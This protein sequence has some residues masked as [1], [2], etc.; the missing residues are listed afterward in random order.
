MRRRAVAL[1][2]ALLGAWLASGVVLAGPASAHAELESSNPEDGA[3]LSSA[4]GQVTLHFSE[5]VS[6]GAGYARVLDARQQRVDTGAPTVAGDVLT[7]PLRDN[8]PEGG[9]LV[10][11]RVISADSHPVAGAFSFAVGNGPLITAGAGDVSETTAPG[12]AVAL[13][14]TRWLGYAGLA[15]AVGIPVLLMVCWPVGW[16]SVR[17]R[18]L[19]EGGAIAA[20]LGAL[21]AFAVQGPYAAGAG[22]GSVFD[23]A[24]LDTTAS[25]SYGVVLMIRTLLALYLVAALAPAWRRGRPPTSWMLPASGVA[26]LGLVVTTA[27]V[28]HP[29]AGPW[30]GLE[31]PI[32][33]VHV[34]AMTVWLGGL[35]GLVLG[36]LR[37]GIA[38]GE[39][40]VAMPRFSRM[41]FGSVVALVVTGI[42]QSV[43]EVG[44][45]AALVSTTYGWLLVAKLLVVAVILAAAGVSRVWVQQHLG[46]H[47]R[48][49]GS[50]RVTAH[51]F[52][53]ESAAE[54]VDDVV[55]ERKRAVAGDAVAAL[56]RL[57][58]SVV[59]E[60]LLAVVVLGV[61][62]VL[63]GTPPAESAVV[64]PVDTTLPLKGTSGTSGSVQVSIEPAS[65]G[66]NVLHLYLFDD[67][68]QL[69]QPAGITVT[70][71][72]PS[73]QLGPI[74]VKL[75]PAGPGHY[76]ADAMDI[77]AAGTW[78][79]QVSVRKDEFT[80]YTA[81]TTFPVR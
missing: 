70:I 72:E 47:H 38:A 24:L 49:A 43:R 63:V 33:V 45:P 75:Q 77:P 18:R 25:T 22:L 65:T 48:P 36:V 3:R 64:Q 2:I 58:R 28:G 23:T 11:Y 78:T 7:I 79:L 50:R 10:T 19:S 35:A 13:P 55:E 76:T 32:A 69:A 17:L 20:A 80:A 41:A 74:D 42:V 60:L 62:S 4:P 56:P 52:A 1:L 67:A 71:S 59:V 16:S 66:P 34:A 15:L 5:G 53:A 8:L 6:L 61:T 46:V 57:R 54:D 26:A 68:G 81:S 39:L 30:P 40:A 14:V 29:V 31:L 44:S 21:G 27:A 51:A 37:P 12:V 9:Y 73:Q